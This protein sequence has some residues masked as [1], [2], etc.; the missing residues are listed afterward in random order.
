MSVRV[1]DEAAKQLQV[2]DELFGYYGYQGEEARHLFP[3]YVELYNQYEPQILE[4]Q[5]KHWGKE[6]K[7]KR[8]RKG[9]V[10]KNN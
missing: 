7:K 3:W 9:N 2:G 4:R 8:K 1:S 10:D 6:R 5:R